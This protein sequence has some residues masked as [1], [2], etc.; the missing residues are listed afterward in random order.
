MTAQDISEYFHGKLFHS[1][2][3]ELE[4]AHET[5]SYEVRFPI[6]IGNLTQSLS[7]G[8]GWGGKGEA[9]WVLYV[10]VALSSQQTTP[11]AAKHN[12]PNPVSVLHTVLPASSPCCHLPH[13][14]Q[15]CWGD[16]PWGLWFAFQRRWMGQSYFLG[17]SKMTPTDL[18]HQ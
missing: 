15:L 16:D 4:K 14:L 3:E 7:K 6:S 18:R 12:P 13:C 9:A 8:G 2:K 1:L 5:L 11:G 17:N 10:L